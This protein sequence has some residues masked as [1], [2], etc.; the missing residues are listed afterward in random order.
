MTVLNVVE[1][2]FYYLRACLDLYTDHCAFIV[3]F[4]LG[5]LLLCVT[6]T[7]KERRIFL[8]GTILLL[9]TVYNPLSPVL[10]MRFFDVNS[11][12]YR[13]FWITP[14]VVLLP[15]LAVKTIL[16]AKTLEAR[17][18]LGILIAVLFCFSGR[19]LYADGYEKADNLYKMPDELIRI[20]ELI[21]EDSDAEYPKAFLEFEYNMQMRQ[22]DPKILLTI[23]RE[24]YLF[25]ASSDYSQEMIEDPDHPQNRL[26][27][28]LVKNQDVDAD[29]LLEALEQ[30]HTEYV[31]LSKNSPK[32]KLLKEAGLREI[33][34]TQDRVIYKYDLREPYRFELVDYSGVY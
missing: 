6:G 29:A 20:S 21:H 27:A 5:A 15:Y 9:L 26:L 8:P 10:L 23:D 24:E 18:A 7:E 34:D 13:F 11:E 12:Y 1:Q 2:G 17:V 30:T 14:V 28:C 4:F 25:A 19:F 22:Y 33:A 31:V 3:L 16:S 32:G